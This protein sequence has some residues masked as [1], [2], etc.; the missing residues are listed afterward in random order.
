[1]SEETDD[2]Y[3]SVSRPPAGRTN[4]EMS[5]IGWVILAGLVVLL[6]PVLP[7]LVVAWAV[8]RLTDYA[9]GR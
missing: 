4:T 2:A 1:M 5:A 3:R 9:A 6:L 7:F 8:T